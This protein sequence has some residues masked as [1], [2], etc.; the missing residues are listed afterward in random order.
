MFITISLPASRTP[1][2]RDFATTA[3][4]R[5]VDNFIWTTTLTETV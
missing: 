5:R 4:K 2:R 3:Q 1:K